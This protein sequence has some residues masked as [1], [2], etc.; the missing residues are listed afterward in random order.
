MEQS[1][2]VVRCCRAGKAR[3][4]VPS[5]VDHQRR[6]VVPPRIIGVIGVVDFAVISQPK[7][8]VVRADLQ[9][10]RLVALRISFFVGV[11]AALPK[12]QSTDAA[13]SA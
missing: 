4:H 10:E 1:T 3:N 2:H 12:Q 5:A 9:L 7:R 6:E 11:P 13:K 8:S